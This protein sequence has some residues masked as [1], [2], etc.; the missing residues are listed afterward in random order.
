MAV[1]INRVKVT[2]IDLIQIPTVNRDNPNKIALVSPK[3]LDILGAIGEKIAKAIKGRLVIVPALQLSRSSSSR[4]FPN[5]GP[6]EVIAGRRLI[7]IIII[8]IIYKLIF[9]YFSIFIFPFYK[10]YYLLRISFFNFDLKCSN[11]IGSVN[12]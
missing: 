12:Q 8:A 3:V 5:S 6:T 4:I 2:G 9:F 7:P 11:V 10:P 1:P